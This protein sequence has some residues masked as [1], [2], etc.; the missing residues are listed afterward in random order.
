M[1]SHLLILGSKI[2][3]LTTR[4]ENRVQANTNEFP[5]AKTDQ[6]WDPGTLPAT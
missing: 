1:E 2:S 6:A 4:G 3:L 5:A